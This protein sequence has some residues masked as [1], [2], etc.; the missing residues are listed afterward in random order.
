MRAPR[1]RKFF[2]VFGDDDGFTLPLRRVIAEAMEIEASRL[3]EDIEEDADVLVHRRDAPE[4]FV[5]FFLDKAADAVP[6]S[7]VDGFEERLDALAGFAF[8]KPGFV[9]EGDLTRVWAQTAWEISRK[10]RMALRTTRLMISSFRQFKGSVF[11]R[12]L[13]TSRHYSCELVSNP[14]I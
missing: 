6:I 7:R 12:I 13:R 11:I 14:M 5:A 9:L 10:T 3:R 2:P 1:K 8:G 4:P